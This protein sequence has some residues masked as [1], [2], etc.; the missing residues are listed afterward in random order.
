MFD[1]IS[2]DFNLFNHKRLFRLVN[3]HPLRNPQLHKQIIWNV[4]IDRF[5][6]V[7]AY[8]ILNSKFTR[9]SEWLTLK[10]VNMLNFHTRSVILVV[11]AQLGK[12]ANSK[13]TIA[14]NS[15]A[16]KDSVW[17]MCNVY[18]SSDFNSERLFVYDSFRIGS[19]KMIFC[20]NTYRVFIGF[21]SIV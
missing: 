2:S 10:W 14:E 13:I 9:F 17:C 15:Y 11:N 7:C 12:R 3:L 8:C 20:T 6:L 16:L 19:N 5:R 4:S 21:K 18:S 1:E